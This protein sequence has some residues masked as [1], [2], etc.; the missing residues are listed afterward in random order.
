VV[1]AAYLVSE[2]LNQALFARNLP[3]LAAACWLLGVVVT[4]LAT[5]LLR[6]DLL[7]RVAYALALGTT[8]TAVALA[9]AHLAARRRAPLSR[10]AALLHEH[11]AGDGGA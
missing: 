11:K 7:E 1:A 6:I 9:A 10:H 3:R 5:W 2:L 8:A 4:G